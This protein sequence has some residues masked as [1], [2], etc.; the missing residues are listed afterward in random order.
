LLEGNAGRLPINPSEPK[1]TGQPDCPDYLCDDAKGKWGDIIGSVPPGMITNADAPLLE[2]YCEA[3]ATH[4]KAAEMMIKSRDLLGDNLLMNGKPSPYLK[5][6]NEAAKTMASLA[7]RLGLSP[8][9]RSGLKLGVPKAT[10]KWSSLI[11]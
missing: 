2:A 11:G 4:K 1:P 7:T 10:N 6:R 8:A 3:W 5:I 9:D